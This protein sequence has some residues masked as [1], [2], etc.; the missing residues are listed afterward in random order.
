MD[1][2]EKLYNFQEPPH[3]FDGIIDA[4]TSRGSAAVRNTSAQIR[5]YEWRL[6]IADSNL[7]AAV[8]FISYAIVYPYLLI[9]STAFIA[10]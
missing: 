5:R 2:W 7:P 4:L 6:H 9:E 10:C 3:T 8:E 1:Q